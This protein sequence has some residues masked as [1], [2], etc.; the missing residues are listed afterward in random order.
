MDDTSL[1]TLAFTDNAGRTV[2][3]AAFAGRPLLIVN[4][5]SRCGFTP[6]YEGLQRLHEKYSDR[7][8]VVLG[9]PCDQ[10]GHQE[11]GTDAEIAEFCRLDYGVTFTLS[12]K[13]DV[14]GAGT[15]PVFAFLKERAGGAMGS[16]IKWN[17]TKFLVDGDGRAVQ[18]YAPTTAPE[19][20]ESD[21][22]ALLGPRS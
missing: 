18:R 15:H 13:I 19:A 4:T 1:H 3:L 22:E 14:N 21:I 9:F 16:A 20:L 11:P 8:L 12:T 2:D 10:F 6:Q 17:F 5:A 7:G